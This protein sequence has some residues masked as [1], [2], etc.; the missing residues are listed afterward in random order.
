M[1][2]H[3]PA[4]VRAAKIKKYDNRLHIDIVKNNNGAD[5]YC[6]KEET[7]VEGPW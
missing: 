2:V 4:N 5:D 7:R 6:M 3:Y 1:F